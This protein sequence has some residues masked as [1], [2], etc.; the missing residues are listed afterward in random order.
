MKRKMVPIEE[1]ATEFGLRSSEVVDRIQVTVCAVVALRVGK[2]YWLL[3]CKCRVHLQV[4]SPAPR[5]QF[6]GGSRS[7]HSGDALEGRAQKELSKGYWLLACGCI[8]R[9]QVL[10]ARAGSPLPAAPVPIGCGWWQLPA[11]L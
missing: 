3:A 1:A 4:F 8:D 11:C 5:G 10:F 2:C 9:L 7:G 6:S